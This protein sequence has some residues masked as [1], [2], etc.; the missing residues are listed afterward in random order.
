[1]EEQYKIICDLWKYM[2]K[3]LPAADTDEWAKSVVEDARA[4]ATEHGNT[5]F[6]QE[7]VQAAMWELD[8]ISKR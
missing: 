7:L 2:K 3:H 5:K 8:R 1:M 4:F 6:A